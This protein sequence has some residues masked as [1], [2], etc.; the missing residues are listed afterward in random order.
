MTACFPPTP[1]LLANSID[2]GRGFDMATT[3]KLLTASLIALGVLGFSPMVAAE[4][5]NARET[6]KTTYTIA[7]VAA[8]LSRTASTRDGFKWDNGQTETPAYKFNPAN[9]TNRESPNPFQRV[10]EATPQAAYAN[11]SITPENNATTLN[12][13]KWGVRNAA[14]AQGFK[15]GVR[16]SMKSEGFKWGVRNSAVAQGFKWGVRNSSTTHGFKWG[17]RNIVGQSGFKWGVRGTSSHT[18]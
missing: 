1:G 14:S 2:T 5:D 13:F 18:E 10:Y 9:S 6:V 8:D 12:G 3:S 11:A 17:V 16:S 7:T 4:T 15:W